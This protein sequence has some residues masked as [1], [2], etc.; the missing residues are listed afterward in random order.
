MWWRVEYTLESGSV[1]L[2]LF[3]AKDSRE[4]NDYLDQMIIRF[5]FNRISNLKLP[6]EGCGIDE[7]FSLFS[8]Y[9]N[10]APLPGSIIVRVCG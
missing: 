10:N 8:G 2:M 9:T 3:S 4:A 5:G 6:T 1:G 7:L